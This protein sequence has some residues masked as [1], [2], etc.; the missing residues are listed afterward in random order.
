MEGGKGAYPLGRTFLM[1]LKAGPKK[2]GGLTARR[3]GGREVGR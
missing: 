2:R 3:E 1:R